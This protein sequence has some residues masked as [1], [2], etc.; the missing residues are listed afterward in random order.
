[1]IPQFQRLIIPSVCIVPDSPG[2]SSCGSSSFGLPF[3][4]RFFV[5]QMLTW[6]HGVL[7]HIELRIFQT[8]KF[9]VFNTHYPQPPL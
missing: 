2:S 7:L 3:C 4:V 6:L 5:C 1:M 9:S 8:R